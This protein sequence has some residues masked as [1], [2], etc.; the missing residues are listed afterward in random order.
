MAHRLLLKTGND[1]QQGGLAASRR[2]DEGDELT[3]ADLE[4]DT[5]EN[6]RLPEFLHIRLKRY[7][8]HKLT[9]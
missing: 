3:I 8:C 4:F 6:A 9:T 2:T 5:F 7:P 1:T